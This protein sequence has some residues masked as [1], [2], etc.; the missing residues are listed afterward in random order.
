MAGITMSLFSI[1][2]LISNKCTLGDGDIHI[3]DAQTTFTRTQN[4]EVKNHV[5][6][7]NMPLGPQKTTTKVCK[8]RNWKHVSQHMYSYLSK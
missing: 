5:V 6:K 3:T 4:I 1:D 8:N 7:A 2:E